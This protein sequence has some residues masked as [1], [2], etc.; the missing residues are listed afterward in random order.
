M[1]EEIKNILT[2]CANSKFDDNR[3]LACDILRN[4]I[5]NNVDVLLQKHNGRILLHFACLEAV[6]LDFIKV[7]IEECACSP[8]YYISKL[9]LFF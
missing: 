4:K 1:N 9:L 3:H 5:W 7:M 6:H 8:R 2:L